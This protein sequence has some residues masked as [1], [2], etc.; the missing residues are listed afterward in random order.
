[1]LPDCQGCV[2]HNS[3]RSHVTACPPDLNTRCQVNVFLLT[4][5]SGQLE[6]A[7]LEHR[8]CAASLTAAG[9]SLLLL[10]LLQTVPVI[11]EGDLPYINIG[12]AIGRR[13]RHQHNK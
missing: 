3:S 2:S 10:L 4:D 11:A 7:P 1:M 6:A 8:R 12:P 5:V 13:V 9:F